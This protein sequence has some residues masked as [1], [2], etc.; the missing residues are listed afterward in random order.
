M[1]EKTIKN[2]E[3]TVNDLMDRMYACDA[4]S[5]DY[6]KYGDQAL[7]L[8]KV[9]QEEKRIENEK[10]IELKKIEA[11]SNISKKDVFLVGGPILAS[12]LGLIFRSWVLKNQLSDISKFEIEGTY[13]S[14]A[15][16]WIVGTLRDLFPFNKRGH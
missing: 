7:A 14:S 13:T 16:R 2:T 10:E 12:G 15:G 1:E 3:Q 5:E 11:Q 6:T 4:D 8:M 9:L